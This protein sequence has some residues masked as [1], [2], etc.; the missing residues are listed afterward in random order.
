MIKLKGEKPEYFFAE[1]VEDTGMKILLKNSQGKL[2][3]WFPSDQV[4]RWGMI[5]A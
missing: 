5:A 2:A 1:S 3:G 4:E